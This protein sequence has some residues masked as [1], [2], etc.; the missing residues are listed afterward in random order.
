MILFSAQFNFASNESGV[1]GGKGAAGGVDIFSMVGS[2][3]G[4]GGGGSGGGGGNGTATRST[5]GGGGGTGMHFLGVCA[6]S[7]MD[8]KHT[9]SAIKVFF[10][11]VF[12]LDS[13]CRIIHK[14]TPP[15]NGRVLQLV[16]V[17]ESG[18]CEPL[19]DCLPKIVAKI[20]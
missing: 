7:C 3:G 5:G 9:A 18:Y 14:K 15:K 1:A 12:L 13:F 16:W 11:I 2:G 19:N 10:M 17:N 8:I 4:G 20:L 6:F